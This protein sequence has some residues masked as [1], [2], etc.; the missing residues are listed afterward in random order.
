MTIKDEIKWDGKIYPYIPSEPLKID[1]A[2]KL[3]DRVAEDIDP[4]AF[5]VI[6]YAMWNINVE[7]GNTLLRVS[8]SPIAAYGHDFNPCLLDERGDFVFF[9]P[10]LQ[11]LSSATGSAV[12]WTLEYRST[13]PGISDGD[14]FLTNDPWVGATHQTDVSVYA[15]LFWEGELF[16]WFAN[17][18]HQWDLGGTTPGSFNPISQDVFWEA[19]CIPPI[20]IVEQGNLRKDLE[21]E[22]IRRSRM[23]DL[24]ALD[25]RAQ[26]TACNVARERMQ[27]LIKKYGP[28]TIKGVMKKLQDNSE[29]AF[30]KRLE[31]IPDGMWTEESWIEL[32][33]EG[34]RH[35]YRNALRLTKKGNKLIFDNKG[36]DPQ[37]G[38]INCTAVAWKGAIASMISAQMLFDQMFVIEGAY[39]HIEFEPIPGTITCAK[40]PA[41]VISAPPVVLL[42][43][44]GLAGLIISRMLC[45]SSDKELQA[46]V[47]SCMGALMFPIDAIAGVDQRGDPYASFLLDPVGGALGALSWKD[48]VNTG[49][50]PWDLQSTMPNVEDNEIF[51]PIVY[52]WRKEIVNSGGGGKYRGGNSAEMAYVLNDTESMTHYTTSGHTIIP[53][54]GLFGGDPTSRTRYLLVKDACIRETAA[55]DGKMPT[56]V[57]ELGGKHVHIAP[58]AGDVV[59]NAEDVF[60]I[61]WTSAA[62]YGDPLERD[63]ILVVKDIEDCY[64]TSEWAREK[65]GV[66]LDDKGTLDSEKTRE[67]RKQYI[68]KRIS[69][70]M[71]DSKG[72]I[73]EAEEEISVSD[74]LVII[75][76]DGEAFFVCR[77]CRTI[78]QNA[79]KNYKSG[80]IK[81]QTDIQEVGLSP[82]DPKLFIDDEIVFREYFCP[83]CGLLFQGDFA[84]EEDDDFWD[85][86]LFLNG[87]NS[88]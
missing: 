49:G 44:I 11:Y 61:A 54:P 31:T 4:I 21:E 68:H 15:P 28:E 78:I 86:R 37:V 3:H 17:T 22:Y 47:Q 50:W 48:G 34:D 35:V 1:P 60:S 87:F 12:K 82:I 80:C 18:L 9:G 72:T 65:Y 8:G 7:Q 53:G 45:C 85:I 52:L 6:R 27:R 40:F 66:C 62:G 64:I 84:R 24:V 26:I 13:N 39:R 46:E 19:G 57:D 63:P 74:G 5:E 69:G 76:S 38:S 14:I 55:K 75:E 32:S 58:K 23:P 73:P 83:S 56:C 33:R 30:L 59:Q 41:G 88:N 79:N 71:V 16:C 67:L 36:T 2:V 81:K 10:F 51:Y 42:Q 29:T 25:L 77:K 43:T 20:K 70:Q